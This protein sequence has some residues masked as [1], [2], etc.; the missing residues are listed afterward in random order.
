VNKR[1][2]V[3]QAQ[4]G[5]HDAFAVL[6]RATAA[7]LDAAARLILRDPE[8]AKDA[9]QD[10]YVR[11]WRDLR[12]L[13]DADRFDQWLYRLLANACRD[14]LRRRSHRP[15]EVELAD[16]DHPTAP[17][18]YASWGDRDQME[19]GFRSLKPEQRAVVVLHYYLGLPLPEA[20]ATLGIPLGTA[21][22]RLHHSLRALRAAL[23]ADARPGES[24]V[25]GRIA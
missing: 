13:R 20:A 15:V 3:E 9:V 18:A 5:D 12:G 17:D 4:R 19:R 22:S 25:G 2:L 21:K 7:R 14:Q 1:E 24:A 11:A 16:V 10:A 8:A 6:S 23:E